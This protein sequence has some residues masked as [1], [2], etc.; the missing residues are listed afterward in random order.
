VGGVRTD[1]RH[2]FGE[3][4]LVVGNLHHAYHRGV[5]REREQVGGVHVQHH[6]IERELCG[7]AYFHARRAGQDAIHEGGLLGEHL[8]TRH[9]LAGSGHRLTA[10]PYQHVDA[11]AGAGESRVQPRWQDSLGRNDLG[12]RERSKAFKTGS[13]AFA[14]WRGSGER[15]R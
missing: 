5:R 3:I 7:A 8:I 15:R 14:R 1:V 12:Q 13:G 9:R 4:L 11:P 10:Q 6:G 2:G